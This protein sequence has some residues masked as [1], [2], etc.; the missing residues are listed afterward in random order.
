MKKCISLVLTFVFML[1]MVNN[2]NAAGKTV[3]GFK[4]NDYSGKSSDAREIV[5]AVY[6]ESS[7]YQKTY[8][9]ATNVSNADFFSKDYTIKYW[10]S[11]GSPSGTV[12]GDANNVSAQMTST[13]KFSGGNL[14][15][16]FLAACRQL[17]GSGDNPRAWYAN[18]MVGNKAVR[19]ICGYHEGAPKAKD[20]VVAKS[21]IKFAKT[22]ESVKSSWIK[23]NIEVYTETGYT[24]SKNFLV[25]THNNNSQYSRF[26]G[27]P[28]NTYTRPGSSS[29]SILR[30]SYVNQSGTSQPYSVNLLDEKMEKMKKENVPEAPIMVKEKREKYISDGEIGHTEATIS[31]RGV[32]SKAEEWLNSGVE[33]EN[34]SSITIRQ[35][36]KTASIEPIVMAEVKENSEEECEVPV[37]YVLEY[38]NTYNGIRLLGDTFTT[39]VDDTGVLYGNY[40]WH[41]VIGPV[42]REKTS[43]KV[44]VE[45]A[46]EKALRYQSIH[47]ENGEIVD[48]DI[49]YIATEQSNI[50]EPAW[51]FELQSNQRIFVSCLTGELS[52][53]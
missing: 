41:E 19:V 22:G 42:A 30:F 46:F 2:A 33:H 18:S 35:D 29:T 11:H 47:E 21:F 44:E 39:I 25:L 32:L 9:E 26:E 8:R 7:G 52:V 45:E 40:V 14:E 10:S 27:F 24:D 50:F 31:E 3:A 43:Q 13:T 48:A 5:D 38:N 34:M 28:G 4:N 37:A 1:L 15:F 23:S 6:G 36:Q 16:L 17:T 53:K 49:V 20:D 51:M 12:Y